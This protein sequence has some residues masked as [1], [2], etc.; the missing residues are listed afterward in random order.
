MLIRVFAFMAEPDVQESERLNKTLTL[1]GD[2]CPN[3]GLDLCSGRLALKHFLGLNGY[4]EKGT[5]KFSDVKPTAEKLFHQCVAGWPLMAEVDGNESRFNHAV[6][7]QDIPTLTKAKLQQRDI[8]PVLNLPMT[9]C[10]LWAA[11]KNST[12]CKHRAAQGAPRCETGLLAIAV[13]KAEKSP[14][15]APSIFLLTDKVYTTFHFA[16]CKRCLDDASTYR[17]R[18]PL[19]FVD[20]HEVFKRCYKFVKE[21][22]HIIVWEF[23]VNVQEDPFID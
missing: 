3:G 12:F 9:A 1:F 22:M 6:V 11:A 4:G 21:K 8:D 15:E 23:N 13:V 14:T 7:R 18:T 20:S 19:T 5:K 2:R 10:R 16:D 17:L